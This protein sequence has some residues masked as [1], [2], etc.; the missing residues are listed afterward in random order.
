MKEG[1]IYSCGIVCQ[2][3]KG[4]PKN[5]KIDKEMKR[6]ELDRRQPKR[7]H[8]VKLM[9]T[10]G[11]IVLSAI[12]FSMPVVPVQR[13]IKEQKENLTMECPLIVKTYNNS[14][15]GT[16]LI[17]QQK[18]SN[19]VDRRYTK[20]FYFRVFFDFMDIS[21]INAFIVTQNICKIHFLTVRA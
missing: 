8:L 2:D 16:D 3:R 14:I 1:Q 15:K 12:D 18:T 17:N 19:E 4:M 11:V 20:N 5:L 10:K 9:D 7:I 21:Y 6:G 13:R